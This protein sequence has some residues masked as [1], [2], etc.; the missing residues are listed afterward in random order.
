ME[1]SGPESGQNLIPQPAPGSQAWLIGLAG[2]VVVMILLFL[3]V[4]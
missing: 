2:V 4:L 1:R 3:V